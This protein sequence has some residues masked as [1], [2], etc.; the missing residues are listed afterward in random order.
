MR[1]VIQMA[2]FAWILHLMVSAVMMSRPAHAQEREAF[3]IDVI[4]ASAKHLGVVHEWG[5]ERVEIGEL[6]ALT[7]EKR[8]QGRALPS[9]CSG[10]DCVTSREKK[11]PERVR[12]AR[13]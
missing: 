9:G 3:D 6:V 1:P 12:L 11:R 5:F 7:G 2:I 13:E 10:R 8:G 4:P